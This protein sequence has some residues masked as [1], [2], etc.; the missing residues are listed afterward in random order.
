MRVRHLWHRMKPYL[1]APALALYAWVRSYLTRLSIWRLVVRDVAGVRMK[2]RAILWLSMV[3]APVIYLRHRAWYPPLLSEVKVVLRHRS[4]QF[5]LR[6]WSDDLGHVLPSHE[7]A[8]FDAISHIL[9]PDDVFVDGGANIGLYTVL[10]AQRVG[11]AGKIIAVEMIPETYE[12]LHAHVVANDLSNVQMHQRALSSQS[13]MMVEAQVIPQMHG[14]ASIATPMRDAGT[15]TMTVE[16]I[17][18]DALLAAESHIRL[19][20]LDL[21]GAELDA[22]AGANEVL[23]KTDMIILECWQAHDDAY[24]RRL[25]DVLDDAGFDARPLDGR[26]LL[27]IR[28]GV[29]YASHD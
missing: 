26:N 15:A 14:Q 25:S 17:T 13:D 21:E 24:Q 4:S 23:G 8:V 9:R 1:P 22:L 5:H 28:Q 2:D 3:A 11:S 27:A 7:K 12:R 19:M 16:T 6:A 20:K 29:E 18:L 10:G